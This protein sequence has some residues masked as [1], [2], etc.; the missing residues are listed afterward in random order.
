MSRVQKT[1]ISNETSVIT[2]LRYEKVGIGNEKVGMA[3]L[4]SE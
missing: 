2:G 1:W 4:G 3:E